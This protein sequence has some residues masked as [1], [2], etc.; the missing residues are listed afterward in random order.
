MKLRDPDS[1]ARRIAIAVG[2]AA[3]IMAAAGLLYYMAGAN[4]PRAK[5][6]GIHIVA[7]AQAYTRQLRA[8]AQP[9]P[10]SVGVDELV[11]RG[12]LKPED[13]AAFRGL[14]AKVMLTAENPG[15]QTVIM[16]L[17]MR[18]G[19]ELVLLAD[20]SVQSVAR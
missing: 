2:A 20:G 18:D 17:N 16:R 12:F 10:N 7:A 13:V 9:I 8:A 4:S 3:A 1:P 5:V 14:D 15:P 6:N 19:T 11:A